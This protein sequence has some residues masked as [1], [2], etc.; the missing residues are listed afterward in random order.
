MLIREVRPSQLRPSY[1]IA[2]V[3]FVMLLLLGGVAA[4]VV[5]VVQARERLRREQA[6]SVTPVRADPDELQI[7]D[8]LELLK[9]GNCAD[10]CDNRFNGISSA[11]NLSIDDILLSPLAPP[12]E[13]GG[14]R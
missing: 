7:D 12:A 11:Y 13:V 8:E 9:I 5:A 1:G 14:K 3:V 4:S 2:L 10:S 6:I